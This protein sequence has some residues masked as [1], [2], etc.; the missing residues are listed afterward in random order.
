MRIAWALGATTAVVGRPWD[1]RHEITCPRAASAASFSKGANDRLGRLGARE[2]LLARDQIPV[3]H[4]EASP[5]SGLNVV[6]AEL[7]ELGLDPPRHDVLV[8][9]QHVRFPDGAVRK[10]LLDVGEA[11]HGLASDK[12][13]AVLEPGVSQDR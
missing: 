1:P 4:G 8:P 13:G 12:R 11:G 10:I 2:L 3:A 7:L 9:R 5:Q 6:R